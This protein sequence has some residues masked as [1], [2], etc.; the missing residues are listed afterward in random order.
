M[1]VTDL[2]E[3]IWFDMLVLCRRFSGIDAMLLQL[4]Y[5]YSAIC[6]VAIL[7]VAFFQL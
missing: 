7:P 5:V 1:I 4:A 6:M 3:L 2:A